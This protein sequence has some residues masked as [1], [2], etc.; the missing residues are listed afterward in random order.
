MKILSNG[1]WASCNISKSE[2]EL[3]LQLV[4]SSSL[5]VLGCSLFFTV[6]LTSLY[7]CSL[8]PFISGDD[9][10]GVYYHRTRERVRLC[11]QLAWPSAVTTKDILCG[12]FYI[13]V[14]LPVFPFLAFLIP[15]L[16]LH[17]ILLAPPDV[18]L[19]LS[20]CPHRLT[21][22]FLIDHRLTYASFALLHACL[23]VFGF[24]DVHLCSLS[25]CSYI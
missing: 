23:S 11:S 1:F 18:H 20:F 25:Q 15:S 12:H 7:C 3:T 2:N 19:S 9:V 24:R 13:K 10:S 4:D 14:N 21:S 6:P 5:I 17:H 16:P 22:Y 8:V